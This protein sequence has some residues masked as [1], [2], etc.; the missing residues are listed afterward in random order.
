MRNTSLII[1]HVMMTFGYGISAHEI[2]YSIAGDDPNESII[3][4]A[5][6]TEAEIML[7]CAATREQRVTGI[8][9]LCEFYKTIPR[10]AGQ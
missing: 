7:A 1:D 8:R 5:N 9:Q 6:K 3:K 4:P 10:T 2:A